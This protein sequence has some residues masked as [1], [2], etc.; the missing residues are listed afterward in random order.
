MWGTLANIFY[1]QNSFGIFIKI[2]DSFTA[3]ST[4]IVR[5]YH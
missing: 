4:K 3:N 2:N 5:S 1:K